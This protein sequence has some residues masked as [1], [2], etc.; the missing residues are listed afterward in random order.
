MMKEWIR[1][2]KAVL[3]QGSVPLS[4]ISVPWPSPPAPKGVQSP[5]ER[6]AGIHADTLADW[7]KYSATRG[8]G[9]HCDRGYLEAFA[10]KKSSL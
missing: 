6:W 1:S 7:S 2:E 5:S 10:K 4:V 9:C 8:T 3:W